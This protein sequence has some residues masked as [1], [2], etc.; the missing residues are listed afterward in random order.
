MRADE[1]TGKRRTDGLYA[2]KFTVRREGHLE[3]L[4]Y[5]REQERNTNIFIQG[6]SIFHTEIYDH[7]EL[8]SNP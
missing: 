2:N 7:A 3:C 1:Q 8:N 4:A 6:R 5:I